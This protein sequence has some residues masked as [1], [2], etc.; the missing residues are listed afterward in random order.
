MS[1]TT[2]P[3]GFFLAPF[4]ADGE[5]VGVNFQ[6]LTKLSNKW[7]TIC[8]EYLLRFGE[9]F[10]AV[11]EGQLSHITT[12]FTSAPSSGVAIGTFLVHGLVASSLLLLRGVQRIAEREAMTMF[13]DSLKT[14]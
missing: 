14:G 7:R 1:V 13:V 12:R 10:E 9:S 3:L 2:Q 11:W 4:G 6:D 8:A 5:G